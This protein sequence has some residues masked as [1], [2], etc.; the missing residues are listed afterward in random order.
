[1]LKNEAPAIDGLAAEA[2][3]ELTVIAMGGR[4][5]AA[6]GRAF[7][8]RHGLQGPTLRFDE[9]MAA[10]NAYAV[11]GQPV[12]VLLDHQGRERQRWLGAF[13]PADVL[14]AARTL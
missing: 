1:M 2:D 7:V 11:P 13:D 9:P 3:E 12:G 6:D 8:D 14:A 4:D 10:W 5:Q